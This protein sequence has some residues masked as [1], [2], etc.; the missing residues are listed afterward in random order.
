M[1]LE[2]LGV[3]YPT[4]SM[5][6]SASAEF[7]ARL[8]SLGYGILWIPEAIGRH[9]FVHAGWL[10]SKTTSL[11]VATG[12]ASIYNRDAG[13]SM[14]GA[15][16]LAELSGGRFILGLGV[17]HRPLVEA[18]RGHEYGKPLTEMSAYLEKM[19]TSFY[20]SVEPAEPPPVVI[21]ALGPG[22]LALA[23]DRTQGA[24]PYFTSPEHTAIA[25]ETMG[26]QGWLCVEQK[27]ILESSASKARDIARAT[28]SIYV[29]LP[30]YRN[31]WL[32]LGFSRE[33]ID[34]VSDRF[35]DRLFA[36][37]TLEQIH[38]RVAAH[39]AAGADHV[40]IQPLN[41]NGK[42]GDPDW[43]LLEAFA[44]GSL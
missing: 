44:P 14:A 16:T 6:A 34:Q 10:L 22:M 21:A 23:A 32:R 17:S 12:I 18:I 28:A 24:L 42:P 2:K 20:Q 36:W 27:V 1:K 35:I 13:S 25:R 30:N 8:E 40:C 3:W 37:G 19:R 29:G 43:R 4:D 33:E 39:Y 26:E 5:S 7:A 11:V 9:P 15:K 41:P 38:N 31:N